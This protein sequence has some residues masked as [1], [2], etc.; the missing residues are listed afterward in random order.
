[1]ILSDRR[2]LALFFVPLIIVMLVVINTGLAADDRI[3]YGLIA[4]FVLSQIAWIF[5]LVQ[6]PR[7]D[8]YS[9]LLGKLFRDD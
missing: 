5:Y 6:G 4:L 9:R 2:K 3:F 7:Q 8:E 1:M